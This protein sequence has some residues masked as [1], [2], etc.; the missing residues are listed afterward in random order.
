MPVASDD[1]SKLYMGIYIMA[2]AY[3]DRQM[4]AVLRTGVEACKTWLALV[5]EL[6]FIIIDINID[7]EGRAYKSADGALV[8]GFIVYQK[9]CL[10]PFSRFESGIGC[11]IPVVH[12]I[13][14]I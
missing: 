2:V 8:A 9:F 12:M 7:I 14:D 10:E 4:D 13:F 11:H 6:Q 1:F 3:L 5:K